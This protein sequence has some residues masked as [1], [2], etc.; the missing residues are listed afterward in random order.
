MKFVIPLIL[1]IVCA[2]LGFLSGLTTFESIETWYAQLEKPPF[3]PPNWIFGPVW[4]TLYIMMGVAAGLIWNT[5]LK[6]SGVKAAL[7]AFAIQFILNLIWTPVFFGQH[8][9]FAALVIIVLLWIAILVCLIKFYKIRRISGI[10][11]IPYLLWV[12]FAT[13]LNAALWQLNG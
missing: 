11:L 5:G 4:T 9:I 12:S 3:N 1:A 7:A 13:V 6:N 2:G 10:L 8:Q